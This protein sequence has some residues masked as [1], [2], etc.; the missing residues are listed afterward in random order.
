MQQQFVV[1]NTIRETEIRALIDSWVT[2]TTFAKM[3]CPQTTF[4]K[5]T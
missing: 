4:R 3:L 5:K 1:A 2:N